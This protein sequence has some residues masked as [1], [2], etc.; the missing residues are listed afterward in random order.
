MR[1][2]MASPFTRGMRGSSRREPDSPVARFR[3]SF[4]L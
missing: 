2:I 3:A 4:A 1:L